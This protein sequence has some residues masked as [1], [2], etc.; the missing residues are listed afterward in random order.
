MLNRI[1]LAFL[2]SFSFSADLFISEVAEGS[3]NNKYIEIFNAGDN[4]VDLSAYSLSSCS[5]GCDV[6]GEWD[7]LDNVTFE[8]TVAP[9]DVYVVCHQSADE[10]ILAECDQTFTY[11]SNGDD[12]FALT[13]IAGGGVVDMVGDYGDDPGSGWA[14]CGVADATKDHTLVRKSS[15]IAGNS[16]NWGASA[17]TDS[18][19]CEWIVLDQNTWDGVGFHEMGSSAMTYIVEAGMTYYAPQSLTIDMGDT[20][21]WENVSGFHDVVSYDGLFSLDACSGPCTIGEITFNEPG[22]YDYFCS[23][24]NHEQQGMIGTIIVEDSE[25]AIDDSMTDLEFGIS[26]IYPNPFNPLVNF[27]I[28]LL[29]T[30]NININIYDLRGNKIDNIYN[31]IL[32]FGNHT[33]SWDANNFATGIYIISCNSNNLFS[34]QKVVLMK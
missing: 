20:V 18:E 23:V 8:A 19:D 5:N 27:D 30:E 33:F 32:E 17:G 3:S 10:T 13:E 24:G 1:L 2:F 28:Q 25:L 6:D 31:G 22:E 12:L 14:V 9:G 26:N 21:I 15:V 16:G 11:L 34:N 4:D 29:E 7:Y